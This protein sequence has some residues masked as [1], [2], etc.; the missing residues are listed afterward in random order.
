MTRDEI[1]ELAR[2]TNVAVPDPEP[3]YWDNFP[4]LLPFIDHDVYWSWVRLWEGEFKPITCEGCEQIVWEHDSIWQALVYLDEL[5]YH[6]GGLELCLPCF[7]AL[8][9]LPNIVI[10]PGYESTLGWDYS[11]ITPSEGVFTEEYWRK[12]A[13]LNNTV[14]ECLGLADG[15]LTHEDILMKRIKRRSEFWVL[16]L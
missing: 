11:D 7:K 16:S 14:D 5:E 12:K 2:R 10:D 1:R 8:H 9:M 3:A 4:H 13:R 15:T 6:N